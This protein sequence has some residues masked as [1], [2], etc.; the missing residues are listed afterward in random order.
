[1]QVILITLWSDFRWDDVT[2]KQ[3][4]HLNSYADAIILVLDHIE[5]LVKI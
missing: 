3:F 1:M 4:E 5:K 2:Y